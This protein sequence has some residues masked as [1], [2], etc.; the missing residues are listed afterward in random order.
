MTSQGSGRQN[1]GGVHIIDL[2]HAQDPRLLNS[3]YDDVLMP[4][5]PPDELSLP[6]WDRA[7]PTDYGDT[8]ATLV[9]LGENEVVGGLVAWWFEK[10]RTQ[11]VG[12]LGVR[13]DHRGRGIGT[14]L[15]D[16]A[17]EH[18]W[19]EA[20]D[21]QPGRYEF[22]GC[23]LV[24]AEIEDPRHH[25][26]HPDYG[27]PEARVRFYSRLGAEVLHGRDGNPLRYFQPRVRDDTQRVPNLF[28]ATLHVSPEALDDA[29]TV[30]AELLATFLREYFAAEEGSQSLDDSE[31]QGLLDQVSAPGRLALRPIGEHAGDIAD[32]AGAR[33]GS[34]S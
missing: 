31:V 30:D 33:A 7:A 18:W 13:L 21:S 17:R 29:H 12:Y 34:E 5:F 14:A 28:L 25:G 9:A 19:R 23:R 16:A 22:L 26:D 20:G 4:S 10:A 15:I 32:R 1:V 11:L 8:M 3:L 27:S 2:G 6:W 24:V